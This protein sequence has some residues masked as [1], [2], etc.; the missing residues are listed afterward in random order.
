LTANP[1]QCWL[2]SRF[3]QSS[4]PDY[5]FIPALPRDN[6][7]LPADY[8]PNLERAFKHRPELVA[9]YVQGSWDLVAGADLVIKPSWVRDA[10][11]HKI[12]NPTQKRLVVCDPAR[13]GDDETVI[14]VFEGTRVIE[15]MIYGQKDTMYTAGQLA[16]LQKKHNAHFV[17]IDKGTFGAAIYDRLCEMKVPSM[18]IDFGGEATTDEKKTRYKNRRAEMYWE[19]GE[20]F[21]KQEVCL[22]NDQKLIMQLCDIKYKPSEGKIQIEAKEDIKERHQ[23]ESPDRAD[24]FVMGL[25]ALQFVPE[26]QGDFNRVIVQ[27]KRN[28]S[29]GWSPREYAYA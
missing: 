6:P 23:N 26:K 29:Y 12:A 19:A 9:A 24:A 18:A 28:D 3:L 2:V 13:M 8:I 5:K 1:A 4:D 17:V 22:H 16:I 15:E 20:M 25:H 27:P 21:S 14:Y 10:V 11:D 7:F